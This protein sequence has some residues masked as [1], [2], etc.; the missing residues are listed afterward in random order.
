MDRKV[1]E[2]GQLGIVLILIINQLQIWHGH[3]NYD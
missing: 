3:C 1:P 2:N